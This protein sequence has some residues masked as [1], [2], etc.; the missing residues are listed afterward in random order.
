MAQ[1]VRTCP[2]QSCKYSHRTYKR[3]YHRRGSFFCKWKKQSVPRYQCKGCKKSFSSSTHRLDYRHKKPYLNKPI[4]EFYA[5]G[6]TQRRL[7]KLMRVNRKTI[8]A[9]FIWLAR[10][11]EKKHREELAKLQHLTDFQFDEMESFEH[12]RL[13]PVSI[14]LAVC[15]ESKKIIGIEVAS[16]S[17]KG[18]LASFAL[19]KYGYR[20]DTSKEAVQRVLESIKST[21]AQ[22][23]SISTDEKKSYS[24]LIA[25]VLPD[26]K[27]YAHKIEKLSMAQRLFRKGRRNEND[28]LFVLNFT[29]AKIR[30][31]LSR[32][33]RKTWVTTKKANFLQAHL[34]LYIAYTNGYSLPR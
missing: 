8:A 2:N 13:K 3:F 7:A 10:W 11:A 12:T 28:P 14:S 22:N 25:Q 9:K 33:A 30:H 20:E 15:S 23:I 18:R 21:G 26:S 17:Y 19:S 29:A 32:M 1:L 4:F 5:S 6:M 34:N 24:K 16:L 27:H 31:D